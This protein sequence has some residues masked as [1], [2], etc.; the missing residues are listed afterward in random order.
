MLVS[1]LCKPYPARGSLQHATLVLK[2]HHRRT[3]QNILTARH[4][5]PSTSEVSN[6]S[7]RA[8]QC[9]HTYTYHSL[10]L[11]TSN[12]QCC[13]LLRLSIVVHDVKIKC[14]QNELKRGSHWLLLK[15][16]ADVF[17]WSFFGSLLW[18]NFFGRFFDFW[19][20]DAFFFRLVK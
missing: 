12:L 2:W 5:T 8:M 1:E 20:S 15:S 6:D 13:T 7:V 4:V 18:D 11:R 10:R 3:L 16:T 9:E 19:F 17:F 14:T